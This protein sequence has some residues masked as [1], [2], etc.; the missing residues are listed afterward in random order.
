MRAGGSRMS[1]GPYEPAASF[2]MPRS[3]SAELRVKSGARVIDVLE[4]L[5]RLDRPARAVEMCNA[6]GLAPS[7]ANDLLKTLVHVGYL[8]FDEADKSYFPGLRA[9]MFGNWLTARYPK[10]GLLNELME[11]VAVETGESVVLFTHRQHQ[12]QV[13]A[14][15]PGRQP[16][17]ANKIGRASCRERVCAYFELAGG[18]GLLK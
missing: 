14:L 8:E 17:P 9:A 12:V 16:D 13:L 2:A 1:L 3:D 11:R 15:K 10:L 5:H 4:Y 7:S 18:A 6:L